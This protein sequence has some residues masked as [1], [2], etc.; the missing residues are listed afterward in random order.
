LHEGRK[1]TKETRE[2][3][4]EFEKKRRPHFFFP[5]V[6][7]KRKGW[8]RAQQTLLLGGG[9]REGGEGENLSTTSQ[10][11]I[12]CERAQKGKNKKG[13]PSL[14]KKKNGREKSLSTSSLVEGKKEIRLVMGKRK[15]PPLFLCGE[16]KKKKDR[17]YLPTPKNGR[18]RREKREGGKTSLLDFLSQKKKMEK[19]VSPHTSLGGKK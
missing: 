2:K 19:E 15:T 6:Q 13:K 7:G 1:R 8:E 9:K 12:N 11:K 18:S 3:V 16:K 4:K 10:G 5:S 17:R 14:L